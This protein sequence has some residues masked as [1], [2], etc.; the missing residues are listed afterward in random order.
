MLTLDKAVPGFFAVAVT[1]W[2]ETLIV[3]L[4]VTSTPPLKTWTVA[5]DASRTESSVSVTTMDVALFFS[6]T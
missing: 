3:Q 4:S 6:D 5:R 2:P 1:T